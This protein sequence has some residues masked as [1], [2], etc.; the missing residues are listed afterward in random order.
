[1]E[2]LFRGSTIA[3]VQ[4]SNELAVLSREHHVALELALSLQRAT[5]VDAETVRQATLDFWR[6]EGRLHFRLEEEVLLPA[7]ARHAGAATVTSVIAGTGTTT[8]TGLFGPET[9]T[10]PAGMTVRQDII[11]DI[12]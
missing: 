12:P 8:S 1:V 5:D 6:E 10:I 7:F 3:A 2:S 11:A 4:R 9:V